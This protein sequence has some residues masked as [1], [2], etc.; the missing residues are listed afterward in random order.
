[1]EA[2]GRTFV[3]IGASLAGAKAA[4]TLRGEG[5]A[6]RVVLI[7]DEDFVPYERP[8][9]SKDFMLG[10]QPVEKAYV[11]DAKWYDENKVELLL[12]RRATAVDPDAHTVT[13][14]GGESLTY[15]KLLLATGS[16]VRTL[17]VSG[18]DAEGVH[19]LRT[20]KQAETLLTALRA[21]PRVVIIGAG[22][23]G[24]EI[25][26]AAR[27][28][29]CPVTVVEMDRLPLRR[30]LG[31]EVAAL[32]RDLHA[33]HGVDFRFD[34]GVRELAVEDGRVRAVVL[35]DDT[36][37]P[38]DLV[39]VGVGVVPATELAESA[40]LAVDNG[41]VTDSSLR[42][43]DPDIYACGDV[44][45]WHH[46]LVGGRIRVEH[47]SNA[48]NGGPAAARSMLGQNVNYDRLPYFFTDQYD[49]GMEYSGWV[50]PEDY[51]TVVFRCDRSA[52]PEGVD[53]CDSL[54]DG[55]TPSFLAFWVAGGRVLAGMNV[56]IWDVTPQIQDLVRAGLSGTPVDVTRLADP[57]VPLPDLLP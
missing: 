20:A 41:V 47:W 34:T 42:T 37:V 4:E 1:M 30:V 48:L 16:R 9:L 27:E 35:D 15:D 54:I 55:R 11:H 31:D 2:E 22:W 13:L 17:N 56:N 18:T 52:L 19:Y 45:S 33:A 28:H 3:I 32:F 38:A 25:A 50:T 51:D 36:E 5:F 46:K 44:A 24:L 21:S 49:L 6:G 43:S 14:D 10:R 29:G 8:P 53:D 57:D 7:G 12:G 40:G 39:V 23:I 26:A